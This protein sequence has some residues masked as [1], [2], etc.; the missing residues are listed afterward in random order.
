MPQ[1]SPLGKDDADVA[2]R[3]AWGELGATPPAFKDDALAPEVDRALLVRLVRGELAQQTAESV[4][5]LILSFPSWRDAH[6]QVAAAEFRTT[7][8]TA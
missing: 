7:P 6:A 2:R 3:Q 8:P 4:N 1:S 5:R